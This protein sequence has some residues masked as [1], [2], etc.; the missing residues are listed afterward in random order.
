MLWLQ[1]DVAAEVV[2]R[3]EIYRLH[4][5]S[6]WIVNLD[7]AVL[8]WTI[9]LEDKKQLVD[10]IVL[11]IEPALRL[12]YPTGKVLTDAG[13]GFEIVKLNTGVVCGGRTSNGIVGIDGEP[14]E[15]LCPIPETY[16]NLP[17]SRL[18]KPISG[19]Q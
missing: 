2:V 19:M 5:V 7:E 12:S 18:T 14:I 9:G 17:V 1:C 3:A 10:G 8:S 13:L 16:R 11:D 15:L 4:H 6:L